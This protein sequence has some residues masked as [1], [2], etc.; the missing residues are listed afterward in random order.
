MK[1]NSKIMSKYSETYR[2]WKIEAYGTRFKFF[3]IKKKKEVMIG[4]N[5][6]MIRKQIDFLQ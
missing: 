4:D 2:G 3:P 5:L 1:L 6:P